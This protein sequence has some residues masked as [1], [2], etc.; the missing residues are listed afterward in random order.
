MLEYAKAIIIEADAIAGDGQLLP[1]LT[2]LRTLSVEDF[3]ELLLTMPNME[4]PHLSQ[5]LP[6]MASDETQRSLTGNHGYGLL[7]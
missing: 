4:F 1:V 7:R 2:K 5:M 3:G 6:A